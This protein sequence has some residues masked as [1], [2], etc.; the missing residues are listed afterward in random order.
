M[1]CCGIVTASEAG[2]TLSLHH[3]RIKQITGG[4]SMSAANK[5]E[6]AF[7]FDPVCKLFLSCNK[8]PRV[9]DDTAA[10]WARVFLVP[11]T[12]SFKGREDRALRPALVTDLG[13]QRAVLAW[14]VAGARRYCADGLTPPPSIVAATAA[15]ERDSDPLAD[16]IEEAC[17]TDAE[18]EVRANRFNRDGTEVRRSVYCV[19]P[20]RVNCRRP[21]T[22]PG[23]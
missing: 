18:A 6:K 2:D 10:F 3:D 4:D 7:E 16:F 22:S 20:R 11:F 8:P 15:F 5:Y 9:T 13:H 19:M 21:V 14:I 17:D 1:T 23:R 12:V